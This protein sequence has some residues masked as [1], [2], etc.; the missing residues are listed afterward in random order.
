MNRGEAQKLVEMDLAGND[1]PY[2]TIECVVLEN[3]TIEKEWGWVFFYQSK[4]YMETKNFQHLLAGNAP[5]I[6]NRMS[7]DVLSTGTAYPID[8]Y[9]EEYK[10]TL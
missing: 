1:N 7:G 4:K 10:K 9:I 2:D 5:Y 6:V 8:H 3:E